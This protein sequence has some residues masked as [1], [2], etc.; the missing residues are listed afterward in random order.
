MALASV[1]SKA[2]MVAVL[3]TYYIHQSLKNILYQNEASIYRLDKVRTPTH[4]C[5]DENDAETPTSQSYILERGLS[6]VE[7][8]VK[9]ITFPKE[10]H[11]LAENPLYGKIKVREE[12]KWLK[13]YGEG[14]N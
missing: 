14:E 11:S 3:I 13:N 10:R 6:I 1:L 2:P 9:L 7:I 5:T 4:I 12:L 8:P